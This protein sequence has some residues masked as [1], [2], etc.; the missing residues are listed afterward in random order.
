MQIFD[1]IENNEATVAWLVSIST[2]TFLASLI[3][4]PIIV[5]RIPAD[6]FARERKRLP[7]G[8]PKLLVRLVKNFVGVVLILGGIAMLVLPGQ[9]ILTILIGLSLVHFPGK[10]A[11]ELRIIRL[12]GVSRAINW[13]RRK[14]KRE[15]LIIPP[16]KGAASAL[17]P[18]SRQVSDPSPS[19]KPVAT[20]AS[21]TLP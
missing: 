7:F 11:L 6:Y 20:R 12:K 13:L 10:R 8:G 19:D 16:R 17:D 1:W 5:A 15:P 4:V 21:G 2:F 9:G 3:A 18:D 14:A